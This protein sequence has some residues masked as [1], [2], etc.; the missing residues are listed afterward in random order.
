MDL[1]E[2][3]A[4]VA[5]WQ[6]DEH[7]SPNPPATPEAI[8]RFVDWYRKRRGSDPPPP[9]LRFLSL[10][11]GGQYDNYVLDRLD[12]LIEQTEFYEKE[13]Y[14]RAL[15]Y[16]WIGCNGNV[17]DLI[18]RADGRCAMVNTFGHDDVYEEFPDFGSF[19]ARLLRE[20][21]EEA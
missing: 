16:T 12:G 2:I 13:I 20:S 10:A 11:D 4:L 18:L 17:D 7:Y 5:R 14:E 1:E 3:D 15:P 9:F 8:R 21:E 19:L 6:A